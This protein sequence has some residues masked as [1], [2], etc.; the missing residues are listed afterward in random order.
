MDRKRIKREQNRA[1]SAKYRKI[2][3]SFKDI[4]YSTE[5]CSDDSLEGKLYLFIK[6]ISQLHV[7]YFKTSNCSKRLIKFTFAN[8]S[9]KK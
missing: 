6:Y 7:I 3:R 8:Y 4:E 9:A 5:I 2:V 1:R